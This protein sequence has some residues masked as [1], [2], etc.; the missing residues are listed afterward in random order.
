[1][2][3]KDNYS[4]DNGINEIRHLTLVLFGHTHRAELIAKF[5]EVLIFLLFHKHTDT[6]VFAI[7]CIPEKGPFL[8]QMWFNP[9]K[10]TSSLPVG[11]LGT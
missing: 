9:L 3:G 5:G 4:D 1:M 7:I 2:P 11:A 8:G 10:I 6:K